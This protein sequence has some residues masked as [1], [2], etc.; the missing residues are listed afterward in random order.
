MS[1]ILIP[2]L[3][4]AAMGLLAG[5]LLT[6]ASIFF[7]VKTDPRKEAITEALP[8]ANCGGCGYAGCADYADAI[9]QGK[10]AP[11]LCKPGGP[12][13]AAAIGKVLGTA[14]EA[15]EPE[16][17]V[18]HCNGHCGAAKPLFT[19]EGTPTCEAAKLYYG[20]SGICSHGCL[21]FGDCAAVCE[22]DAICIRDGIAHV[23]SDR[24]LACGKCAK[25]CPN[26][27]LSLRPKANPVH[28]ACSSKDS[29]KNT[30]LACSNGCIGCKLCEKKCP[31]GAISVQDFHAV[32][33]YSKCT[34]CGACAAACPVKAIH[35]A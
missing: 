33:D 7:A 31:H 12:D 27:L 14:V 9:V 19:Y 21:G 17:M 11:N 8:G 18:V 35:T 25:V 15:A 1:E 29:G 30:K 34:G 32:I 5:I 26:H 13:T 23:L 6:A 10:A 20:G 3:I 4:F 16:V 28:V 22:E 2:I 24:C